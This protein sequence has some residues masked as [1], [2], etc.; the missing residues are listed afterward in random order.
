MTTKQ[1][2]ITAE[3]LLLMPR[4]GNRYELARGVLVQ[5][6]PTG[7]LHRV[8]VSR[9][10]AALS[11]WSDENDYGS[12]GA[13]EPGYRL[14]RDPDTVR[15]PDVVWIAPGRIPEGT[16]GYPELAPDLAVEVKSPGNSNP[17]MAA[18]AAMWL[19]YGSREVWVADPE[20]TTIT[21]H[22]PNTAPVT[23]GEDDIL[24]SAPRSG[25]SSAEGGPPP[26]TPHSRR[27]I[28]TAFLAGRGVWQVN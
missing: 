12:V 19:S 23:L 5:K 14:D 28:P 27:S 11:I 9:I 20:T 6:M 2:F 8:T 18:K 3:E 15:A 7:D 24:D 26:K 17:E 13:G 10:D 16:Q 1:K 25:A 21:R 22:R 4:D